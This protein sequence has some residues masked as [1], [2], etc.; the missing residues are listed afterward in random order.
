MLAPPTGRIRHVRARAARAHGVNAAAACYL[1]DACRYRLDHQRPGATQASAVEG[2]NPRI[3]A[4]TMVVTNNTGD[5]PFAEA[6]YAGPGPS[7]GGVNEPVQQRLDRVEL[8]QQRRRMPQQL[9]AVTLRAVAFALHAH[10][11]GLHV[12][13]N[14][15][16]AAEL[17]QRIGVLGEVRSATIVG[18]LERG[19]RLAELSELVACVAV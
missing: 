3:S 11:V 17:R 15:E 5:I 14:L 13:E 9:V 2:V 7:G 18:D 8:L 10:E 6:G 16:L 4:A 12:F 19:V 1:V